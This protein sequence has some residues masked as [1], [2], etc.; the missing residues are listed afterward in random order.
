MYNSGGAVEAMDGNMNLSG[1]I[2]KIKGRGYGRF[3][4]YS[5]SKPR[6][7]MVDMKEEEFIYNAENG[8][9]TVDVQGDCN[10]R[11]IEFVY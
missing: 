6:S 7:C 10:L 5:S 3:G 4:A 9:L 1:C 11:G 8:L 2:I